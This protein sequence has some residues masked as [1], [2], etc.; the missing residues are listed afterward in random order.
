MEEFD[1]RK[2]KLVSEHTKLSEEEKQQLLEK[3]NIGVEKLP[4]VPKKD[5]AIQH[6]EPKIGDVIKIIRN[7]SKNKE[8]PFYRVVIHG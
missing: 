7:N 1:I 3:F 8:I 5:P 2:H 4:M 6:L